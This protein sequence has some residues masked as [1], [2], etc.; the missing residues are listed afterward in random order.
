VG[1]RT[2]V[3]VAGLGAAVFLWSASGWHPLTLAVAA[4]LA[5][6]FALQGLRALMP[7]PGELFAQLV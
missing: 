3:A 4:I 1:L 6:V 7:D 2:R 5:A